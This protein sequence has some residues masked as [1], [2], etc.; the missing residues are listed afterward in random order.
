MR[1]LT[2]QSTPLSNIHEW[3]TEGVIFRSTISPSSHSKLLQKVGTSFIILQRSRIN[4]WIA[5]NNM[6]IA[7]LWS[8]H[9]RWH[10]QLNFFLYPSEV[11]KDWF[12][13][14]LN[15]QPGDEHSIIHNRHTKAVNIWYNNI[16]TPWK[17]VNND[18]IFSPQGRS[19]CLMLFYSHPIE[20]GKYLMLYSSQLQAGVNIWYYNIPNPKREGEH[21]MLI[22]WSTPNKEVKIQSH[23]YSY[24]RG[25]TIR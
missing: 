18:I 6:V 17:G 8:E 20:R 24:V 9:P 25:T 1:L 23:I 4:Q 22:W 5:T 10:K 13:M 14:P 21:L 11:K 16:L 19:K 15:T 2:L 12:F 3:K 7:N